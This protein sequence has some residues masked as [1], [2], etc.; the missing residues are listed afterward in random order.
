MKYICLMYHLQG[1]CCQGSKCR[2]APSHRALAKE[3]ADELD[4]A[5]M[6]VTSPDGPILCRQEIGRFNACNSNEQTKRKRLEETLNVDQKKSQDINNTSNGQT[7]RPRH[8][9]DLDCFGKQRQSSDSESGKSLHGSL[10]STD[11]GIE[12][13]SVSFNLPLDCLHYRFVR[14]AIVGEDRCIAKKLEQN[15][16]CELHFRG[17]TPSSKEKLLVTMVGKRRGF[18]L[19]CRAE[20]EELLVRNMEKEKSG[21]FSCFNW[22]S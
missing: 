8:Q 17:V 5:L 1:Y 2:R 22:Q 18:L 3:E 12:C 13:F 10:P 14:Y 19:G 6:A 16:E 21:V 20:I 4:E 9:R 7:K 11:M 15:F